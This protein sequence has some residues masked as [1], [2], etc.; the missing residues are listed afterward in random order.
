VEMRITAGPSGAVRVERRPI[1]HRITGAAMPTGVP[2]TAVAEA[3]DMPDEDRI[4]AERMTV[5]TPAGG[6]V[7]HFP[8]VVCTRSPST[9]PRYRSPAAGESPHPAT[10][11]DPAQARSALHTPR[12]CG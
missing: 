2:A 10:I 1:H 3:G 7:I 9:H 8:S 6:R 5:W 4:R 12:R 11:H